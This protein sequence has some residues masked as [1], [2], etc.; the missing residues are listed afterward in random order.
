MITFG[1]DAGIDAQPTSLVDSVPGEGAQRDFV[2]GG[3]GL[4]MVK[5]T[6]R[7]KGFLGR[8]R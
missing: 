2:T 3:A 8:L 4:G 5:A 7:P 1:G 6:S